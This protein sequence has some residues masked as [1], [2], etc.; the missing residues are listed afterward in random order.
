ML[1]FIGFSGAAG[2]EEG[3]ETRKGRTLDRGTWAG[4]AKK[5]L[6]Q[7]STLEKP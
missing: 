7:S 6:E 1:F 2:D 4:N 3:K 5:C